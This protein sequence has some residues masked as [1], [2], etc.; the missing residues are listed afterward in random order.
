MF[1]TFDMPD[2]HESCARRNVTI[3][4]MQALTLLNNQSSLEWAQA[5]AG[6]VI[7]QSGSEPAAQI[8]TCYL[9][10][11]CRAP[12]KKEVALGLEFFKEQREI[13]L[14]KGPNNELL[15]PA[16][17]GDLPDRAAAAALVDYCHMLLNSNE[18]VYQN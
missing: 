6:K 1:E 3:S 18:F 10:A 17:A 4:P 11:Y 12:E 7:N 2:T 5:F 16:G 14:E 13:I 9:N 8:E 15:L